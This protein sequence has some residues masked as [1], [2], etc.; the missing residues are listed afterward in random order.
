MVPHWYIIPQFHKMKSAVE[1]AATNI[2]RRVD[3]AHL[4][5]NRILLPDFYKQEMLAV[6]A[7][8]E[9]AISRGKKLKSVSER[10]PEATAPMP[11]SR[12]ESRRPRL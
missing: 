3:Q 11:R 10:Q 2:A 12:A 9:S 7:H 6:Q 5:G 1:A 4:G 8:V